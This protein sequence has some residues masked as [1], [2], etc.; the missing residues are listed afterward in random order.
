MIQSFRHLPSRLKRIID[1]VIQHN[2]YFAHAENLLFS[3]I[4]DERK[5]MVPSGT[6]VRHFKVPMINFNDTG[7]Y[8][9]NY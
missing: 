9:M 2:G 5:Y 8:D 6:K 7:Y 4:T 1:P 3:M